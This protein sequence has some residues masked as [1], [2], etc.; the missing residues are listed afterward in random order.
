[1]SPPGAR[2]SL[3]PS[4]LDRLIEPQGEETADLQNSFVMRE[5]QLLKVDFYKLLRQGDLSQNIYL[6]PDDFVYVRSASARNV[7]VLGAVPT[8]G[9]RR[10]GVNGG[11][12]AVW[13]ASS[14]RGGHWSDPA[15]AGEWVVAGR[16]PVV[17]PDS[18][19]A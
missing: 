4:V 7:Y 9:V 12:R 18:G 10:A 15:V 8:V 17:I 3:L 1:M 2:S 5:G 6:Q 16:G 19:S 11:R 14:D 13:L